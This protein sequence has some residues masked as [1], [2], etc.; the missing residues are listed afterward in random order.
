M[1]VNAEFA[2]VMDEVGLGIL[3]HLAVHKDKDLAKIDLL[4][5]G[6]FNPVDSG[7][8]YYVSSRGHKKWTGGTLAGALTA[9]FSGNYLHPVRVVRLNDDGTRVVLIADEGV[10]A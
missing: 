6:L 2:E 5:D 8:S 9:Y 7:A 1:T 4:S 3:R 10:K